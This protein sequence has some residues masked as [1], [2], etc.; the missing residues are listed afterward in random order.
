MAIG[1]RLLDKKAIFVYTGKKFMQV[2]AFEPY[3]PLKLKFILFEYTI[4]SDQLASDEA[5]RPGSTQ[6]ENT[7]IQLECC[8]ITGSKF[9]RSVLHEN[10]QH[11][12]GRY[13]IQNDTI[14]TRTYN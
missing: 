8:K 7:Y 3:I 10:I 4:Y 11:N 2:R 12:K 1:I 14:V 9:G 13:L 6:I 5:I